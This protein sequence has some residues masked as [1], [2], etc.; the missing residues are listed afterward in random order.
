MSLFQNQGA[1]RLQD[2]DDEIDNIESG[3]PHNAAPSLTAPGAAVPGSVR[4][5]KFET[6]MPVRLDILAALAYVFGPVSAVLLIILETKNDYV[7]FHAWQ[8]ALVFLCIMALQV[9]FSLFSS[10]LVWMLF[11]LEIAL[12][13]WLAYQAFINADNLARYEL[14]YLGR[15]AASWV[16]TE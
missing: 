16:D 9:F 5:N 8:S 14:P 2:D 13:A 1:V 7:R 10:F 3:L 4:V 12:A 6:A 15:L 11:A